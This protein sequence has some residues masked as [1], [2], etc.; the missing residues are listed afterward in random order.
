[1]VLGMLGM[2]LML[3]MLLNPAW[4]GVVNQVVWRWQALGGVGVMLEAASQQSYGQ[5]TG[6]AKRR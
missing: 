3:L 5:Q 2:L 1:M 6:R 4:P